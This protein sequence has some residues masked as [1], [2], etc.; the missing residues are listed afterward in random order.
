MRILLLL[1]ALSASL[2]A[3]ETFEDEPLVDGPVPA[4]QE[5]AVALGQ[6]VFVAPRLVATPMR[7]H[8]D[9]RC[10]INARC[11][12][13]GRLILETRIDGPGWRET[14][15]L[16]LGE[17]AW[18]REHWVTLVSAEPG[19]MAGQSTAPSAYRFAFQER[20]AL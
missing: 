14:V 17:P 13:A 10:P 16:T 15:Y 5:I 19:Q 2:A 7:V 18:V 4:A 12:T 1:A 20:G 8:E 3:C 6:P 11:V 9:S